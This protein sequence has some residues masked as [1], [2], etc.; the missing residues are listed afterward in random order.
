M[1]LGK[2]EMK[3]S[4]LIKTCAIKA[5]QKEKDNT[6]YTYQKRENDFSLSSIK[7]SGHMPLSLLIFS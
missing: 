3:R 6:F 7:T 5:K 4:E 2:T 1:H